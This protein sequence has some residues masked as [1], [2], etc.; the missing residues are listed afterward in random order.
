M[1]S[2]IAAQLIYKKMGYRSYANTRTG[3]RGR[4]PRPVRTHQLTRRSLDTHSARHPR[5]YLRMATLALASILHQAE[6][7]LEALVIF[8]STESN[9]CE[10]KKAYLS[11][12]ATT[13]HCT[14]GYGVDERV[15]TV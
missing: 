3:A 12:S 14:V 2:G 4:V 8:G 10:D 11:G 9:G 5:C 7:Y 1:L 13:L 15:G 6:A